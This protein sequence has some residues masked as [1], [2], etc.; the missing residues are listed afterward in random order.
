M[1]TETLMAGL[2]TQL[3]A[4]LPDR[5]VT[6]SL[7][8]DP[9]NLSDSILTKGQICLLADGGAGFFNYQGREGDGGDLDVVVVAF[10]SVGEKTETVAIEQAELALKDDLLRYCQ[11]IAFGNALLSALV[12][13]SWRTS[14]QIEHPFGWVVMKLKARWL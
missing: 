9:A 12:P 5:V 8:A 6:R 3:Q 13:L 2:Q 10:V 7:V 14:K 4:F 1:S 11:S